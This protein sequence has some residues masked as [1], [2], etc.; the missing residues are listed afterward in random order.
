MRPHIELLLRSFIQRTTEDA[1]RLPIGILPGGSGNGL[2]AS[3]RKVSGE[4]FDATAAAF[5][6]AKGD[7]R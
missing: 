5:I 6:I 4:A 7:T 1:I 3:I 2:A